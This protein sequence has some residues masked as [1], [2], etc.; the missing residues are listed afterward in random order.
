MGGAQKEH[1]NLSTVLC[2]SCGLKE[3]PLV[4]CLCTHTLSVLQVHTSNDI[5][6]SCPLGPATD[7][8]AGTLTEMH[9]I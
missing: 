7:H 5:L 6:A 4:S 8:G 2:V 3:E 1:L 9:V